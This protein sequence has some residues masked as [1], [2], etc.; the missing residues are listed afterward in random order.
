[1][2]DLTPQQERDLDV[3]RAL[4]T[5]GI[6]V[7]VAPEDWPE[8]RSAAVKGWQTTTPNPVYVDAWQPGKRLCAVM[9]HGLDLVDL[10]TRNGGDVAKLNGGMPK[11][12]GVASTP[13]GGWHGFIKSLGVR[14]RDGVLPGIDVKAGDEEGQ[15]RGFAFIAPTVK[16]SKVTGELRAYQWVRTP[17]LQALKAAAGDRSGEKLAA[18]VRAAHGSTRSGQ[19]EFSW[20]EI[21]PSPWDDIAKALS[22]ESGGR[23]LGAYKL[24]CALRGRGGWRVG[25]A[26]A[27]MRVTVWP[28][29]DQ[30]QSG[31]PLTDDEFKTAIRDAFTRHED[32]P[33]AGG[34]QS[35]TA[36]SD[37]DGDLW[38]RTELKHIRT[39]ARARMAPPVVVL[40]V[41]LARAI[42]RTPE[43]VT[44]PPLIFSPA[45][46]NLAIAIVAESG[47][48]KSGATRVATE[49]VRMS[50]GCDFKTHSIGTGQG[51]AHAYARFDSKEGVV[52]TAY[53]AMLVLDEVAHLAGHARQNGSTILAELRRF[54]MGEPLGHLYVDLYKRV[55]LPAHSY[56]GAV[57]I[58][59]QPAK[60]DAL[61][62]DVDAGTPQ[63]FGWFPATDPTAGDDM[64]DSPQPLT[65]QAPDWDRRQAGP[66]RLLHLRVCDEAAAAIR[67]G[68]RQRARGEGDP[69]DGHRLL[70]RERFAAGFALLAGHAH[71]EGVTADDW[72][73]AGT[74]LA[75][76]DR[77]R[78]R[79]VDRLARAR[80]EQNRRRGEDEAERAAIIGERTADA[81]LKRACRYITRKLSREGGW[82]NGGPLRSSL[83]GP[84]RPLFDAAIDALLEAGQIE[85]EHVAGQGRPGVRYRLAEGVAA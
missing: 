37:A 58:G 26:L 74:L 78:A 30:Q 56:R 71:T 38:R 31:H 46:L 1:M 49:A 82:V 66:D 36:A 11:V 17:D 45:S 53:S 81:E 25:D 70:T 67:E 23:R 63:R 28:L 52:R 24:A 14:S 8:V 50:G 48:G 73:L 59:V 7:F 39:F 72:A 62:D 29:V 16:P 84:L 35:E 9:G 34:A 10:D 69:L 65:W 15:G 5:A 79:V 61:L 60:A 75:I 43:W 77:T 19:G 76:S 22:I 51:L 85:V 18:M 3:A 54:L 20:D 21:K 80:A 13:S 64:P 2:S 57:I 83:P 44:L 33:S 27:Y 12:Y 68:H 32:G 55:E 6:P 47:A 42:C 41:E 40:A 4:A